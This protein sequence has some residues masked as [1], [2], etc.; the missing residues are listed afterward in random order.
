MELDHVAQTV[1]QWLVPTEVPS[2]CTAD[3][4]IVIL[5]FNLHIHI[6][7]YVCVSS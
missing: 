5:N 4:N 6:M 3:A 2:S 1:G 7:L